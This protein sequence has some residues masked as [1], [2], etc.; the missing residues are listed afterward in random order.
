MLRVVRA[1][2]LDA[3]RTL[4]AG[5]RC[6]RSRHTII[7]HLASFIQILAFR[8]GAGESRRGSM[9]DGMVVCMV[10]GK[11]ACV[12]AACEPTRIAGTHREKTRT[13]RQ[14]ENAV[15]NG[16]PSN[17]ALTVVVL[18][19]CDTPSVLE[20]RPGLKRISTI[21]AIMQQKA[22]QEQHGRGSQCVSTLNAKPVSLFPL[23]RRARRPTNPMPQ[24]PA[25]LLVRRTSG[26]RPEIT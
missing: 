21:D 6:T 18:S 19:E 16:P 25:P 20:R 14:R 8:Q 7:V 1:V 5:N 11:S 23:L 9:S 17:I 22:V 24:R 13:I 15:P 4:Q 3:A 2:E 10:E 12:K 26:H